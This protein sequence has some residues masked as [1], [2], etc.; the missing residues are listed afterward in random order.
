MTRSQRVCCRHGSRFW[1]R[2][3]RFL[4]SLRCALRYGVC[5]WERAWKVEGPAQVG[6]RR[7]LQRRRICGQVLKARAQRRHGFDGRFVR[8]PVVGGHGGRARIVSISSAIMR[9]RAGSNSWS[10]RGSA[11]HFQCFSR[12][13]LVSV[14]VRDAVAEGSDDGGRADGRECSWEES[15][16][17]KVA[18]A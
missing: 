18:N 5:A 15:E 1:R 11:A 16:K 13:W 3:L 9:V 14:A 10:Q 12:V 8:G 6:R 17:A 2:R 7:E 4:R